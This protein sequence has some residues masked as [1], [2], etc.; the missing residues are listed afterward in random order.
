MSSALVGGK[1]IGH[2][3]EENVRAS[4]DV[5]SVPHRAS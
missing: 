1:T 5:V 4:E 3:I 2:G